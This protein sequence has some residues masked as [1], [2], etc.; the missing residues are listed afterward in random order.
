MV[1]VGCTVGAYF[2][3]NLVHI[4]H[5]VRW[6]DETCGPK[7]I[8]PSHALSIGFRIVSGYIYSC[9]QYR[10]DSVIVHLTRIS[11]ICLHACVP[12]YKDSLTPID[13]A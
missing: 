8:T 4:I 12:Q 3:D 13:R 7:V 5:L 11:K 2:C 1:V 10:T 6:A 9:P